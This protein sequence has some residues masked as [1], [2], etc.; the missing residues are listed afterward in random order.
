MIGTALIL[1]TFFLAVAFVAWS[2]AH[3]SLA[4]DEYRA[5]QMT[6]VV[7]VEEP[8]PDTILPAQR[9]AVL[10]SK[11]WGSKGI[12]L[13]VGFPFDAT[14]ANLQNKILQYAN[15]WSK[16]ANIQFVLTATDPQVRVTRG[17]DGY[18]SY[19][20]TDILSIARNQPT[21]CFQ[22]FTMNTPDSEFM[23]VVPHEFGHTCGYPHE[24]MRPELV[25]R[26][27]QAK[28]IAYFQRTQG[29]SAQ[30]TREQVL[31]PLTQASIRG[32]PGADQNSIMCY[33]LPGSITKDGQPIQGGN[34][35]DVLDQDYAG[36]L[37]PKAEQPPPIKPP[38]PPTT[39]K[40]TLAQDTKA[41]TY[42]LTS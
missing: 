14:P 1:I 9:L 17:A 11:Y 4:I 15:E 26:L 8:P 24:H 33:Q 29:W 22:G 41:G 23:R 25:D 2:A 18:W 19:L 27:D 42:T 28:T 3:Q 32:T 20:G 16:Y 36:K 40:I 31:T 5:T 37:Y 13:T 35:I 6:P 12:K 7:P 30:V 10:V 39:M 21:M 38:E 34:N